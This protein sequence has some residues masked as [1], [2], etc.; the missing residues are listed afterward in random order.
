MFL[1]VHKETALVY[2]NDS[3][4]MFWRVEFAHAHGFQASLKAEGHCLSESD[5]VISRFVMACTENM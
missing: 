4:D 5:G 2:K 1:T 3:Y